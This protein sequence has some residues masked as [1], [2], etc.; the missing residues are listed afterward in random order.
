MGDAAVAAVVYQLGVG[1]LRDFPTAL[2]PQQQLP[3]VVLQLE[4]GVAAGGNVRVDALLA[5][6]QQLAVLERLHVEL[7]APLPARGAVAGEGEHVHAPLGHQVDDAWQLGGVRARDRGHHVGPHAR[8]LDERDGRE[9]GVEGPGHAHPIVRF[10]QTVDG[11]LVLAA[12]QLRQPRAH[13]GSQVEGVAKHAP[14][15]AACVQK[16]RE[17]PEV[18]VQHG[19][20]ARQV[21]VGRAPQLA[22][23]RR[24]RVHHAHHLAEGHR[25]QIGMPFGEKVAVP[26]A[27]VTL[28]GD[29]E[30]EREGGKLVHLHFPQ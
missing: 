19:V 14:L 3:Q 16:L 8:A 5:R 2:F 22:A 27:L 4:L 11:E 6:E 10:A 18:G 1:A 30:L 24:A 25:D 7:V 29:V 21:E 15:V 23:H 12:S 13:L 26:A 17:P 20:A 28:V 9:R